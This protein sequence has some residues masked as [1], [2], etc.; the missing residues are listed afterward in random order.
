MGSGAAQEFADKFG[1]SIKN[2]INE[3]IGEA[4]N[5]TGRIHKVIAEFQEG[6]NEAIEDIKNRINETINNE[7]KTVQ[8]FANKIQNAREQF[9]DGKQN[10]I[11]EIKNR[12]NGTVNE[13]AQHIQD[14][15][16]S[17][18]NLEDKID[19][20][21]NKIEAARTNITD[22]KKEI[23]ERIENATRT[24]VGEDET[25]ES[26]A[27]N[28]IKKHF[29]GTESR[30]EKEV[31]GLRKQVNDIKSSTISKATKIAKDLVNSVTQKSKERES[32]IGNVINEAKDEIKNAV[33][34]FKTDKKTVLKNVADDEKMGKNKIKALIER[35]ANATIAQDMKLRNSIKSKRMEIQ[36]KE[37][38]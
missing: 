20:I 25:S 16:D 21:Y 34:E 3:R 30:I 13:V 8:K 28:K 17:K 29:R 18:S 9:A 11:Q 33:N 23:V 6:K 12:I 7:G 14:L 27:I 2:K 1:G 22:I 37:N 24:R 35:R 36:Q 32:R 15:K 26:K 4:K 19:T 10:V 5:I 31:K 38:K